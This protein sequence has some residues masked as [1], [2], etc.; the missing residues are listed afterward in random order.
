MATHYALTS[1][2]PFIGE[3]LMIT[4]QPEIEGPSPAIAFNRI[5]SVASPQWSRAIRL[6]ATV[7][8]FS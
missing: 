3:E 8:L 2:W 1:Q 6:S 4:D 5:E 7:C